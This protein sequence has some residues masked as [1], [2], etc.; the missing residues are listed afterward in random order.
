MAEH[1]TL[2]PTSLPDRDTCL[3]L[4]SHLAAPQAPVDT[5]ILLVEDEPTV[6]NMLARAL[7][8]EGYQIVGAGDGAEAIR[9]IER[10]PLLD[11]HLLITDLDMP[12]LGG[13]D[14]TRRLQAA[15]RV[16]RVIYMTG[17]IF[18]ATPTIE[19]ASDMLRKPFNLHRLTAA[20]REILAR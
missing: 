20:V 3:G 2:P 13:I 16:Q 11:I 1:P 6:R 9:L 17:D 18:R 19:L 4:T 5:T 8:R 7:R 15:R 12:H 10:Q 14:L